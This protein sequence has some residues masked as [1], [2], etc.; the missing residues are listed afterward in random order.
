MDF[1]EF[2]NMFLITY[3]PRSANFTGDVYACMDI[4]PTVIN[5]T[6]QTVFYE[7]QVY[8]TVTKPYI[9][10]HTCIDFNKQIS[11]KFHYYM[12]SVHWTILQFACNLL[13]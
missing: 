8:T 7:H 11:C 12:Q 1:V 6:S 5:A 10:G 3:T 4:E 2:I 13:K 9:H